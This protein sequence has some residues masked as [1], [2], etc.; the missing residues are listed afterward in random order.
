MITRI[1]KMGF[2]KASSWLSS[3]L[4]TNLLGDFSHVAKSSYQ[5][6]LMTPL[7]PSNKI[8]HSFIKHWLR[9]TLCQV[10]TRRSLQVRPLTWLF[11]VQPTRI[12]AP[13]S[14][15]LSLPT[16]SIEAHLLQFHRGDR[17]MRLTKQAHFFQFHRG[18]S[19]TYLTKNGIL[20]TFGNVFLNLI[21]IPKQWL[22][23]TA[24]S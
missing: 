14:L 3:Q 12:T 18:N 5:Q 19:D 17:D 7:H 2:T 20:N 23:S 1:L 13:G 4:H 15:M 6:S 8:I 16:A 11:S 22:L 21:H 24:A 9:Q 10:S